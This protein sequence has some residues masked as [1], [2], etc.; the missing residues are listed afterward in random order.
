MPLYATIS[1]ATKNK[2]VKGLVHHT[3]MLQLLTE[4]G[5]GIERNLSMLDAEQE[6]LILRI[7]LVIQALVCHILCS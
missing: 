4:R 3:K 1:D 6:C 7:V 2:L 5:G